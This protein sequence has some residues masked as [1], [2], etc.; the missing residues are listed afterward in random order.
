MLLHRLVL[1]PSWLH[2]AV[3]PSRHTAAGGEAANSVRVSVAFNVNLSDE[4]RQE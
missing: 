4:Q 3:L 1:F 2:H